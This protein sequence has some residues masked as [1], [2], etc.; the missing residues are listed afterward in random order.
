M[1]STIVAWRREGRRDGEEERGRRGEE[2]ERGEGEGRRGEREKRGGEREERGEK[3]EERE[4]DKRK[5]EEDI[6]QSL[7]LVIHV[8]QPVNN[9][10]MHKVTQLMQCSTFEGSNVY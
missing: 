7:M 6:Y 3:R 8:H 10:T 9:M 2:K 4:G 1:F 5:K